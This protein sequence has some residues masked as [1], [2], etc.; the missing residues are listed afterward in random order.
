MIK[1]IRL[2][3]LTL[4]AAAAARSVSDRTVRRWM[5]RA[6]EDGLGDRLYERSCVPI[7]QP[8]KTAPG[9]GGADHCAAP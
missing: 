9:A 7:H 4:R 8:R 6:L 5:Q 3:G 2:L 1:D